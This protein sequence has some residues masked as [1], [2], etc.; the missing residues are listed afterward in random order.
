MVS[1]TDMKIP[2]YV[3]NHIISSGVYIQC[4]LYPHNPTTMRICAIH[5][6]SIDSRLLGIEYE[7]LCLYV[8]YTLIL[9]LC[10]YDSMLACV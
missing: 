2:Y 5:S 1:A 6:A 3:H 10:D 9:L 7:C 8:V 4:S